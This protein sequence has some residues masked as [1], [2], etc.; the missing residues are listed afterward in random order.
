MKMR[1]GGMREISFVNKILSRMDMTSTFS[2][3]NQSEQK[4]VMRDGRFHY[5]GTFGEDG[6]GPG[7]GLFCLS[8]CIPLRDRVK[9]PLVLNYL[10]RRNSI[11]SNKHFGWEDLEEEGRGKWRG[12]L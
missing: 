12:A 6:D 1:D 10:T 7:G 5:A 11:N 2:F 9:H 4:S 3:K 8:I